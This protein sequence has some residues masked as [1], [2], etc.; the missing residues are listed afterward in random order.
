CV[1]AE[2]EG[3]AAARSVTRPFGVDLFFGKGGPV[4]VQVRPVVVEMTARVRP[5]LLV[6]AAGVGLVLLVA[7]ANVAALTLSR[8]LERERELAVRAAMGASRGRLARQLLTESLLVAH[9]GG[10]LG[11]LMAWG[12]T[13]VLPGL[14]PEG[15]PRIEN[16]RIDAGVMAFALALSALSG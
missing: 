3:T 11:L 14:A 16:V 9:L 7:C 10:A 2:A 15:F 1:Q 6:L 13:R 4:E 8:S 12:V 5:A